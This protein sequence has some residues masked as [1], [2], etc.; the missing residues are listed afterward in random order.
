MIEFEEEKRLVER[1]RGP[2]LTPMI[3]MV[4]LLLVFFLLTSYVVL[5]SIKVSLPDSE[6]AQVEE[7]SDV[8]LTIREDRSLFLNGQAV[9]RER[10]GE[11]LEAVYSERQTAELVIESDR[12]VSF[13]F[14]VEIMDVSRKAGAGTISFLVEA[15]R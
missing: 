10:L 3:D 14:V 11:A 8:S 13:G 15:K 9:S 5:P 6:T 7:T 1:N 4:F 12:R 2:D